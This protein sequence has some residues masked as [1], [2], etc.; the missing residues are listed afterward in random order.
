MCLR[1]HIGARA[2]TPTAKHTRTLDCANVY[3]QFYFHI[4]IIIS[5]DSSSCVCVCDSRF[6]FLLSL[7]PSQ[8]VVQ[9]KLCKHATSTFNK[10]FVL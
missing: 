9:K 6:A 2:H 1:L 8:F 5:R 10:S 7:V 4:F 3:Q